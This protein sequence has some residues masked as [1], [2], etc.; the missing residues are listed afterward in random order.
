VKRAENAGVV[1]IFGFP[2]PSTISLKNLT[3]ISSHMANHA[4]LTHLGEKCSLN[5][6]LD[7]TT[8]SLNLGLI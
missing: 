5:I 1:K 7:L 2:T 3:Q 8:N 4:Q 6:T